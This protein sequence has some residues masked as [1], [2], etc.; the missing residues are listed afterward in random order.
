MKKIHLR[1]LFALVVLVCASG[2]LF[3]QAVVCPSLVSNSAT[4]SCAEPCATLTATPSVDLTA[5]T[6]Y[7]VAAV[8][9]AP[10]AYGAGTAAT[11]SGVPWS[12]ST[13]DDYGDVVQLPFNFCFFG[14]TYSSIIIGTNGNI[15]FN[16]ALA[17]SSDPWS[18]S[19]PMPGS[20]CAATENAI[21]AVWN[22]TYVGG[23]NIYHKIYVFHNLYY[24]LMYY[25]IKSKAP[26]AS[27]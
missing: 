15:C 6:T 8:T 16:T 24:Y 25:C 10:F 9:Y 22:D 13:D 26:A 4:L 27:T 21:M 3:G 7:S 18:I 11:F 20:N 17:N 5:T 19:G 14:N 1:I 2:D 23:G 12:T